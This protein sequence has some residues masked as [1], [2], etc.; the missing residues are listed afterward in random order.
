LPISGNKNISN[1][2]RIHKF[3]P[4][5]ISVIEDGLLAIDLKGL[6]DS[7]KKNQNIDLELELLQWV[8][9]R[10]VENQYLKK[11]G[12]LYIST[13]EGNNYYKDTLNVLTNIAIPVNKLLSNVK[14]YLNKELKNQFDDLRI[15]NI[16]VSFIHKNIE[17]LANFLAT[18]D[19]EI[20]L[21]YDINIEEEHAL[22]KYVKEEVRD[23]KNDFL[24]GVMKDLI[25]GSTV[26]AFYNSDGL[27][28]SD[29]K[30]K[31]LDIFL[32]Y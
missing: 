9:D 22:C 26:L 17:P 24:S 27:A 29:D 18:P 31:E 12:I 30:F 19:R 25:L 1:S 8:M 14:L 4:I 3:A 20:E 13:L 16:L 6:R 23:G 2:I 5:I 28:L 21:K 11:T 7:L 15:A 32:Y 10:L